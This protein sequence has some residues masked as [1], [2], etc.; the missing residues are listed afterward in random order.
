MPSRRIRRIEMN[1]NKLSLVIILSCLTFW[2]G[3]QAA[4]PLQ[5][6]AAANDTNAIA[7]LLAEGIDINAAENNRGCSP[8][9]WAARFNRLAAA[10]ALIEHGAN[11]AARDQTG[12]TPLHYAAL[13][14]HSE[15]VEILLDHKA[16]VNSLDQQGLSPLHLAA[17]YGHPEIIKLLINYGADV[18]AQTNYRGLTPLHWAAFWGHTEA[19]KILLANGAEINARDHNGYT[20]FSWAEQNNRYA[21]ARLLARLGS[22]R[23]PHD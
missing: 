16:P 14:G 1:N 15:M 10:R 5:L 23:H 11:L 12:L 6:A 18:R 20:P 2:V 9:H 19:V 4:E 7:Q 17:Q 13:R 3:G 8:L 22:E 21:M